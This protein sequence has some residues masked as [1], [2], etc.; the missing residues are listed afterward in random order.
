MFERLDIMTARHQEL[1]E[2]MARPEVVSDFEQLRKYSQEQ[3]ELDDT[4]EVYPTNVNY[5]KRSTIG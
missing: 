5:L 2:L 3:A 4:V 1:T